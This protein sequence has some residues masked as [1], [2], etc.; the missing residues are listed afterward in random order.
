[1]RDINSFLKVLEHVKASQL[2]CAE[3]ICPITTRAVRHVT[4]PTSKFTTDLRAADCGT[5]F[6]CTVTYG[7]ILCRREKFGLSD[8]NVLKGGGLKE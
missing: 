7:K 3:D 6:R 8:G 4:P 2:R 1:M 5:T